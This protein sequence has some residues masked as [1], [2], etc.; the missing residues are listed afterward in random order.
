MLEFFRALGYGEPHLVPQKRR[1][2]FLPDAT[3]SLK[4]T[5]DFRHHFELEGELLADESRTE[6]EKARLRAICGR[7]GLVP[8]EP[9]AIA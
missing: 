3:L 1:N 8:L 5:P 2:W 6:G 4:F 9:E 7:Y